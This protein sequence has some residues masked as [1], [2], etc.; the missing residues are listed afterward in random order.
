[1]AFV[2]SASQSSILIDFEF[3]YYYC[4]SANFKMCYK[5]Y[6]VFSFIN[7]SKEHLP[8]YSIAYKIFISVNS[9]SFS[10]NLQTS[11]LL[12]NRI[13]IYLSS[14]LSYLINHSPIILHSHA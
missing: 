14:F 2:K 9:T 4:F 6:Y 7:L 1:M 10:I 3:K 12:Y 13:E 5:F 8:S 11:K